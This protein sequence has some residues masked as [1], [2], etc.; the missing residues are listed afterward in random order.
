M[1]EASENEE[2][3][4]SDVMAGSA[5]AAAGGERGAPAY[6]AALDNLAAV[7]ADNNSLKAQVGMGGR[8]LALVTVLLWSD[9]LHVLPAA[10]VYP[11]RAVH[12]EDLSNTCGSPYRFLPCSGSVMTTRG[13]RRQLPSTA[14][15]LVVQVPLAPRR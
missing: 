8:L 6:R 9:G 13:R 14:P 11:L 4:R 15:L 12:S 10:C 5:A 2:E 1:P 3:A 7:T